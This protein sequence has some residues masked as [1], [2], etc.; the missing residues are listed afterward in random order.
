MH[1][2]LT[3]D[4]P[5]NMLLSWPAHFDIILSNNQLGM[6]RTVVMVTT[7]QLSSRNNETV[8]SL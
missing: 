7:D 1:G 4:H 5:V 2:T 3:A 8:A 6:A